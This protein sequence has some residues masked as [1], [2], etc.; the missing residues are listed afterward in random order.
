MSF[1]DNFLEEMRSLGETLVEW[2]ILILVALA[3]LIVG[4]FILKWVRKGIVAFLDLPWLKPLWDRSGV[5]AALARSDQTPATILAGI[6]YAYLMV[7]LWL[8]V[9]RILRIET[10]EDLLVRLLALIPVVLIAAAVVLIAAAVANWTAE[11]IKPMAE[12]KGVGWLVVLTRVF[13]ILFGVLFAMDLLNIDFAEDLVKIVFLAFGAAL[14]ISFGIGGIDTAKLWW[15][16]YA[17][18][19]KVGGGSGGGSGDSGQSSAGFD[20]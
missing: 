2:A 11:L 3:V 12:A 19:G 5:S 1:W 18:P 6:V 16:K 7:V 20:N 15:Q 4:R 10:I 8:V 17:T 14:A 9:V 13:I